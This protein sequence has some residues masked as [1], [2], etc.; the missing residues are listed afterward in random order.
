MVDA[1]LKIEFYDENG[2]IV[3]VEEEYMFSI[4]A[5]KEGYTEV[6]IDDDKEYSTYKIIAKLKKDHHDKSY[7]DKI[8]VV[9]NNA[10]ND[11]YIVQ[12]KNDSEIK[13]K[14]VEYAVFFI[15]ANNSIIDYDS[16]LI[17]DME[18][19][20]TISEK[21][22]IPYDEDYENKINHERIDVKILNAVSEY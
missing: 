16:Q 2:N 4:P 7:H 9:S 12:I 22:Y 8:T 6:Y 3:D 14:Q 17:F 18:P 21:L 1:D 11:N 13:L 15:G 10:Q 20:E 5:N 19:G